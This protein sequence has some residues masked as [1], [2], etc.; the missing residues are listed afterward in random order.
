MKRTYR[1]VGLLEQAWQCARDAGR[2]ILEVYRRPDLGT[3]RKDDQSPVTDA[4][5]AAQAVIDRRL[6]ELTPDWPRLSEETAHAPY[7]ERRHWPRFWLIDPLDGTREFVHRR[8]EFTV[9]IAAIEEGS[10]RLGVVY[11]PVLDTGWV[12][13][14]SQGAW[15]LE[16]DGQGG[17]TEHPMRVSDLP[18]DPLQVLVSYSHP[19]ERL[20]RYLEHLPSHLLVAMGSS[21]K[22]CHL[23]A[24]RGDL[25]PRWSPTCEWDTAAA[26]AVLKAAG[27]DVLDFSGSPLA[28]N[29]ADLKNPHFIA[30]GP[31]AIR[32]E[33]WR[34]LNTTL[35][36]TAP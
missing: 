2:A 24:G 36:E 12:G 30:F 18:S 33:A 35:A 14:V 5:L 27:G 7:E 3:R 34:A 13:A 23:A 19:G 31:P 9:N 16:P 4:D 6:Q 26:H 11:A 25:Y 28:Y 32:Q 17:Y 8:D 20:T 21:L 29:K 1:S 15:R 10:P 22:F